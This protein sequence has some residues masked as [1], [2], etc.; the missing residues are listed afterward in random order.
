MFWQSVVSGLS[1]LLHWQVWAAALLYAKATECGESLVGAF[2]VDR[3]SGKLRPGAFLTSLFG[4]PLLHSLLGGV[5][6]VWLFPIMLGQ[7]EATPPGLMLQCAGCIACSA[8]VAFLVVAALHFVPVVGEVVSRAQISTLILDVVLFRVLSG[9]LVGSCS[10]VVGS[11]LAASP[12][13]WACAGYLAVAFGLL[14]GVQVGAA[15][16]LARTGILGNEDRELW[17]RA[18]LS[19][20]APALDLLCG[21]LPIFMY[22]RYAAVA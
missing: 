12:G 11:L 2:G 15:M 22:V 20:L 14:K 18:I 21:L 13:F 5:L 3:A 17:A 9:R 1:L 19:T 7:S 4:G 8:V 16:L 6:I 10:G